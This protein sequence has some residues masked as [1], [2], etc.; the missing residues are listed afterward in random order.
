[1]RRDA[2]MLVALLGRPVG[3]RRDQPPGGPHPHT[4]HARPRRREVRTARPTVAAGHRAPHVRPD[5][6][7]TAVTGRPSP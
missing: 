4:R 1:M 6:R 7:L 5:L 2:R 3:H